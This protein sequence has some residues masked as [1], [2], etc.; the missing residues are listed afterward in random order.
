MTLGLN[1]RSK[2]ATTQQ[3]VSPTNTNQVSMF[4]PR[5][6]KGRET[7]KL[8]PQSPIKIFAQNQPCLQ[9]HMSIMNYFL[10]AALLQNEH[11]HTALD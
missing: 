4:Q 6:Q 3:G 2:V 5:L 11:A 10:L 7:Y 9:L 1:S 8:E